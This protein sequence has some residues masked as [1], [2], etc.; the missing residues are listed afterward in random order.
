MSKVIFYT[1]SSSEPKVAKAIERFEEMDRIE[2]LSS[3]ELRPEA[4]KYIMFL[5]SAGYGDWHIRR[6]YDPIIND[7]DTDSCG[8]FIFDSVS[9]YVRRFITFDDHRMTAVTYSAMI[10]ENLQWLIDRI[11]K[12]DRML[13]LLSDDVGIVRPADKKARLIESVTFQVNMHIAQISDEV[14]V[15]EGGIA[16]QIK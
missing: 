16:Q 14:I 5:E 2:Y 1:G 15:I 11:R 3:E 9:D 7:I 12:S 10:V 6:Y 13:I 4:F 8:Y